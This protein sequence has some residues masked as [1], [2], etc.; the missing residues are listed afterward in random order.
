MEDL[1]TRSTFKFIAYKK[2]FHVDIFLDTW[3]SFKKR[4]MHISNSA[5]RT[6]WIAFSHSLIHNMELK[7]QYSSQALKK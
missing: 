5:V 6:F 7:I 2:Q 3:K 4:Y 1:V